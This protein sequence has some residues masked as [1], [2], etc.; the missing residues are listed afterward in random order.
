M[1]E[2]KKELINKMNLSKLGYDFM[3]YTFQ[4]ID[5]LDFHHLIIARKDCVKMGIDRGY[6]SW[7]GEHLKKIRE[8]LLYFEDKHQKEIEIKSPKI[9]KPTYFSDRINL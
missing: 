9:I 7:N 4:N 6:Y 2:A 3:G 1:N 8:Y 5:N